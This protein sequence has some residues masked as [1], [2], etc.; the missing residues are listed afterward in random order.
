MVQ[1]GIHH[2]SNCPFLKFKI[3]DIVKSSILA[4][5]LGFDSIWVMDHLNWTPLSTKTQIQDAFILL[6]HLADKIKNATLGTCVTDPH[7]RHPAQ[8]ALTALTMQDLTKGKFILGM[9]AGEGANTVDFCV[10]WNKPATRLIEACQVIRL[11]WE[12]SIRKPVNFEGEFFQLK[13]AGL[14][15]KVEETPLMYLAANGPR[16]IQ[17]AGKIADGW[18]PNALTPELYAKRLKILKQGA[19]ERYPEI[20]KGLQIWVAISKDKPEFARRVTRTIGMNYVVRKEILSA[21]NI[22]LPEEL[23]FKK[24]LTEPIR[25][26][27]KIQNEIMN[28]VSNN[29][30]EEIIDKVEFGGSPADV[31]EQID[32]FIKAGV[33]HFQLLFTGDYFSGLKIFAEEVMPHFK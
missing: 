10:P 19:G 28:F 18:I 16:T 4:D 7:R 9:G 26:Q 20:D 25:Y 30:P 11:L 5:Q 33:E 31:I 32:A 29:V 12:S 15:F 13:D 27:T 22:D 17:F 3:P 23:D 24:H 14:Q 2:G 1:F 8:I 21:Y 6:G